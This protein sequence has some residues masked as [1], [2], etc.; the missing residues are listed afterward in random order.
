MSAVTNGRKASVSSVTSEQVST[1][2]HFPSD[3]SSLVSDVAAEETSFSSSSHIFQETEQSSGGWL[4]RSS[5]TACSFRCIRQTASLYRTWGVGRDDQEYAPWCTERAECSSAE[6]DFP[7]RFLM[8][9]M[10]LTN[11][12]ILHFFYLCVVFLSALQFMDSRY[13]V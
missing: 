3:H 12:M 11:L 5:A 13:T 7:G 1:F 6:Q 8:T 10:T 4:S 2:L 9:F